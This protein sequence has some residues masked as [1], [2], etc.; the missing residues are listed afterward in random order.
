MQ[1]ILLTLATILM[2][3]C[4]APREI[5]KS[6]EISP[7]CHCEGNGYYTI[8][9][10]AGM[11][12]WSLF[13]QPVFQKL[14]KH[15]KV[16]LIDRTGYA[17]DT[18]SSNSRDAKTIALEIEETLKQHGITDN[19]ILVGHSL[20]G[21]HVRMYQSLFP[22]KVKGMILLE[23]AHPN[24]FNRLP[25]AF[26]DL[27]KQQA[28]SLDK[29]IKLAQKGYLQ[30][31]KVKIPTFGMTDS[32]LS[33]YYKVTTQP[34][35][36]YSMKMEVSE[37]ENSLKQAENLNDL[38]NLPLLVIGSKNSMDVTILPRNSKKYPFEKHNKIWFELQ[39]EL[40]KLSSNSTFIESNQ[41]HYLNISD[42]ELVL[43]QI[44]IFMNNNFENK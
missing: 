1:R 35:Y 10:D 31:S 24:Q 17:M 33:D 37:F 13:Y 16:C 23:S 27:H 22:E 25:Q 26:Y 28:K 34:E 40:S 7:N 2:V 38:G 19:I 12:N 9:M 44:I 4:S 39:K 42:S 3:S 15:T 6:K 18:V 14:K 29:V 32:L 36:Y 20:G 5:I 43:E 8:V 11:G 41:N 21:L 30:Y